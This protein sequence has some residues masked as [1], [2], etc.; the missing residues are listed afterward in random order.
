LPEQLND[1]AVIFDRLS[2]F[3]RLTFPASGIFSFL[4]PD[5]EL[6]KLLDLK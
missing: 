6:L 4:I 3:K 1:T 5:A 2:V